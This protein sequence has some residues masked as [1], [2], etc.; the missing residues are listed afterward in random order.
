MTNAKVSNIQ[1]VRY[2]HGLRYPNSD[3]NNHNSANT[4]LL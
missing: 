4:E 3:Y 2:V 1:C